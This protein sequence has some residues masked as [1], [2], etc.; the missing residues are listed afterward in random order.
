MGT[1]TE[2]NIEMLAALKAVAGE[3][4]DYVRPFDTDS[5]LPDH[6]K[7]A[8]F[9]AIEKGDTEMIASLEAQ[10]TRTIDF[11]ASSVALA[12]GEIYIGSITEPS[13]KVRHIILLPGDQESITWDDAWK[14][15]QAHGGDLPDRIEQAMLYAL[16]R[17]EFQEA[18]YWSNT[19]HSGNATCA[20][21]QHFRHGR[22]RD[23]PKDTKLRAR[24]VRRS[25]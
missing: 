21:C 18:A 5:Y 25:Y 11:P 22:Q 8:V 20:W 15:A 10:S 2:I 23:Y 24:A 3:V 13:G 7:Q 19:Q 6:I 12:F 1:P 14:W 17:D 16:H 4:T 9:S